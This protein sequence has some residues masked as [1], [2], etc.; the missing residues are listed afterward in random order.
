MVNSDH[1]LLYGYNPHYSWYSLAAAVIKQLLIPKINFAWKH[2]DKEVML[3]EAGSREAS[4]IKVDNNGTISRNTIP[5]A[6]R[7]DSYVVENGCVWLSA[8][9]LIRSQDSELADHLVNTYKINSEKYKWLQ[10][11]NKGTKGAA[12]LSTLFTIDRRCY[13][14]VCKVKLPKE[15]EKMSLSTYSMERIKVW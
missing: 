12:T 10:L 14:H 5:R 4:H 1:E 11:H 13:L 9:L 2:H 7:Q 3:N 8:C 15:Y 6:Y